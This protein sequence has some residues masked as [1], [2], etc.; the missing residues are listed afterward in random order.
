[1]PTVAAWHGLLIASHQPALL[2]RGR[3]QDCLPAG[4][5]CSLRYLLS[6]RQFLQGPSPCPPSPRPDPLLFLLSKLNPFNRYHESYSHGAGIIPFR[7]EA[8]DKG[9]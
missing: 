7:R 8:K 2:H 5:S 6:L 3:L 1:M 4:A 9:G